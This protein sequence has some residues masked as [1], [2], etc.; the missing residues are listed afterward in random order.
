MYFAFGTIGNIIRV[1][2]MEKFYK[3]KLELY[4]AEMAKF[5]GWRHFD[6]A[7]SLDY[8]DFHGEYEN[9]FED[10]WT[11]GED[12][13]DGKY[14]YNYQSDKSIRY[15][16]TLKFHESWDALM[17]VIVKITEIRLRAKGNFCGFPINVTICGGGGTHI[18]INQG[19]CA[20]EE[21]KGERLISDTMN[22][23]YYVND[24]SMEYKPIELAWIA[25]AEFM[26]WYEKN[27]EI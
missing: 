9:E 18:A 14:T 26:M 22:I 2:K 15:H 6:K 4:N 21:Y 19:N 23:N 17:P 11:E 12:L 24:E 1:N 8:A 5:L 7:I 27:K 10:V 3:G 20:G 13:I 16:Y 25:V